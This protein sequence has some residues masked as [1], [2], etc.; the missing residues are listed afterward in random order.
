MAP[1]DTLCVIYLTI[2]FKCYLEYD[3][4]FKIIHKATFVVRSLKTI[5][6]FMGSYRSIVIIC[7]TF[8]HVMTN[9][10]T[11][12]KAFKGDIPSVNLTHL[13]EEIS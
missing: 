4:E 6:H 13:C 3:N 9:S 8:P 12:Q 11:T 2:H 7:T 5:E 1:Q 10:F